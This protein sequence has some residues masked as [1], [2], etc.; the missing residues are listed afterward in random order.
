MFS[1]FTFVDVSAI[2]T[3]ENSWATKA[4]MP[5]PRGYLG[6]A[7]VN[8]K[9]YA[10]GG[11]VLVYQDVQRTESREVSTNEEYDPATNTWASKA[12][13]PIPSSEFATAVYNDTI[14]CIGGGVTQERD[15][16]ISVGFN[17]VYNP[18]TDKWENKTPMPM[19][20]IL[21][22]ANVIDGKIYVFGRHP[23]NTIN[24]VY[25]PISDTWEI[26]A[27]IPI[28][29]DG[30]SAVY[31]N[32]IYLIG[33]YFVGSSSDAKGHIIE[34]H[35]VPVTQVYY[36]ENDSWSSEGALGPTF[37]VTSYATTTL[38]IN[39][40]KKIY[41]FYNPYG[42]DVNSFMNQVYD[43]EKDAWTSGASF[44]IGRMGFGVAVVD[45]LIYVIGG[46]S[47][48]YPSMVSID[49]N[50]VIT[51]LPTVEQYTPFGYGTV[52]PQISVISPQ[53]T[54]YSSNIVSLAFVVN[55]F[56]NWTGYSLDGK[57]NATIAGNTTLSDLEMGLHNITVFAKDMFG[58]IGASKTISFNLTEPEPQLLPESFPTLLVITVS[59][60]VAI[61]L[62]VYVKKR[63]R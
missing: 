40:P 13:M 56:A 34:S 53:N 55:K 49:Q 26:K 33:S 24:E 35:S 43:P 9:I 63:K 52:P 18:A 39:A 29:I 8:G 12:P 28:S 37:G 61:G 41:V 36:P 46:F 20:Q 59:V 22:K 11:T 58:N 47:S 42:W 25:D 27:S 57:N 50:I 6:V 19:P 48:T 1:L 5:T 51:Y 54:S 14:Y 15:P 2:T 38:G 10:I 17:Q 30:V 4:S 21:G 32:K 23:N 62:L 60:A 3:T 45:D 7:V 31:D 16:K 44:S